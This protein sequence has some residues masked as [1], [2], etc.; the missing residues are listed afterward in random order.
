MYGTFRSSSPYKFPFD[1]QGCGCGIN[2]NKQPHVLLPTTFPTLHLEDNEYFV[3]E[4]LND[5]DY[6][7]IDFAGHFIWQL[8]LQFAFLISGQEICPPL[9]TS[10]EVPESHGQFLKHRGNKIQPLVEEVAWQA[11]TKNK[12]NCPHCFLSEASRSSGFV[13]KHYQELKRD[14]KQIF[15]I[16]KAR[17][18]RRSTDDRR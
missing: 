6:Y 10:L 5:T 13:S 1:V 9:V 15:P 2:E 3:S 8:Q 11:R 14:P 18:K 12:R 17:P 16:Y 4:Y 7:R